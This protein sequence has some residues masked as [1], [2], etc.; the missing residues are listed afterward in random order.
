MDIDLYYI[1][2]LNKEDTLLFANAAG[3]ELFFNRHKVRTV[4]SMFYPPYYRNS[5]KIEIG[6]DTNYLTLATGVNYLSFTYN[7]FTYY[8]FITNILHISDGIIELGVEL[9]TLVTF[10]S[11]ITL[12]GGYVERQFINRWNDNLINRNYV[13]ENFSSGD[14]VY[15]DYK[16]YNLPN[17]LAV[18]LYEGVFRQESEVSVST[19]LAD[20]TGTFDSCLWNPTEIDFI[21]FD[22]RKIA[23]DNFESDIKYTVLNTGGTDYDTT[24]VVHDLRIIFYDFLK[25]E[26]TES[27]FV[28]PMFS[29]TDIRNVDD[30]FVIGES[31]NTVIPFIF[32]SERTSHSAG[33]EY[34]SLPIN[35]KYSESEDDR[36][37][38][39]IAHQ[40][41][42]T[43]DV[44]N[45][46]TATKPTYD[47]AFQ[48][49][50]VPAL[51][52]ENYIKIYF[53]E[54]SNPAFFPLYQTSRRTLYYRAYANILDGSR[55]YGISETNDDTTFPKGT[56]VKIDKAEL[57]TSWSDTFNN[58][59]A[60]N[61]FT[62]PAAV[63]KFLGNAIMTFV[64]AKNGL[65]GIAIKEGKDLWSLSLSKMAGSNA[66]V[67][68]NYITRSSDLSRREE[69]SNAIGSAATND[70]LLGAY[71]EKENALYAPDTIKVNGVFFSDYAS[72][73]C[74]IM[75]AEMIVSDINYCAQMYHRN[76]YLVNKPFTGG[77]INNA[78]GSLRHYF[79]VVKMRSVGVS[80][81][82][83]I[84]SVDITNDIKSRLENGIRLWRVNTDGNI[85]A[86]YIG[87]YYRDNTED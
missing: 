68:R 9:D 22:I 54:K 1:Q 40:E 8:Y 73:A 87:N 33:E 28:I 31:Q 20:E 75:Q 17:Y 61:R 19:T 34:L 72:G 18:R 53:G 4:S 10:Y 63:T 69:I 32:T 14:F 11:H 7:E 79:Q 64:G 85:V 56:Y 80:L 48:Y 59:Q 81:A 25:S 12:I 67:M 57:L 49:N 44:Y 77:G 70:S 45:V 58:W 35:K 29:M 86:S 6:T 36:W 15:P 30:K 26:S 3:K 2:G 21:P 51:Y 52:D 5:I 42:V 83:Y 76:G 46:A 65:A 50:F 37:K 43:L 13:R 66:A 23:H 39:R 41:F 16:Y 84:N 78:F 82:Q 55:I 38:S 71:T 74:R 24:D 47:D 60:N 62:M 27:V